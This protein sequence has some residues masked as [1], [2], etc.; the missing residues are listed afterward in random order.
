MDLW[1]E[2]PTARWWLYDDDS[3]ELA[4]YI[5]AP[6]NLDVYEFG[7]DVVLGVIRDETGLPHVTRHAF[8]WRLP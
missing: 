7:R 1:N 3:G 2:G 6:R 4:G 5:E 8:Q